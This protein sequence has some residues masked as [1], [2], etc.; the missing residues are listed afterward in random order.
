MN[1]VNASNGKTADDTRGGFHEEGGQWG[2]TTSG[3]VSVAPA[4]PGPANL[5]VV[6]GAH[7]DPAKAVDPSVKN[8]WQSLDGTYHVHPSGS[9]TDANGQ[10]LFFAQGPSG[11]D[12]SVAGGGIN[13]VVGA[14]DKKVYFYNGSGVIGKP[15]KLKDFMG[16]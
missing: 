2:T 10:R 15:M 16:Q 5:N 6:G 14:G 3:A 7:M 11:K 9:I 13:I 8:N 4:V 1:A 12:I